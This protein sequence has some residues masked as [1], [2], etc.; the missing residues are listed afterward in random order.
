MMQ[1]NDKGRNILTSLCCEKGSITGSWVAQSMISAVKHYELC[2]RKERDLRIPQILNDPVFIDRL[3]SG[4][5]FSSLLR[6]SFLTTFNE[7]VAKAAEEAL[8]ALGTEERGRRSCYSTDISTLD[9]DLKIRLLTIEELNH[10]LGR[11]I[12]SDWK[13]ESLSQ[14]L[15]FAWWDRSCDIA[16]IVGTF[17]HGYGNYEAILQD[18][19]MP[20]YGNISTW[21]KRRSRLDQTIDL[22]RVVQGGSVFEKSD[23]SNYEQSKSQRAETSAANLSMATSKSTNS[24]KSKF[25][26]PAL[27]RRVHNCLYKAVKETDTDEISQGTTVSASTKKYLDSRLGLIIHLINTHEPKESS[28]SRPV[29]NNS[30]NVIFQTMCE[31]LGL[32]E[33]KVSTPSHLFH[34]STSSFELVCPT[35]FH[36]TGIP[37][38][39]KSRGLAT[40]VYANKKAL[41]R[42][43]QKGKSKESAH[44][45]SHPQDIT[46]SQETEYQGKTAAKFSN[47]ENIP[48]AVRNDIKLRDSICAAYLCTGSFDAGFESIVED[49]WGQNSPIPLEGD[50]LQRYV[51][52]I[53]IPHCVRLCFHCFSFEDVGY[54]TYSHYQE[55]SFQFPSSDVKFPDPMIELDHHSLQSREN[56]NALLRRASLHN[57][58]T[59]LFK[60]EEDTKTLF[61]PALDLLAKV[62]DGLPLW[63][64]SDFDWIM[65]CQAQKY[66]ILHAI[67]KD[68]SIVR[69]NSHPLHPESLRY[70]VRKVFLQGVQSEGNAIAMNSPIP[71]DILQRCSKE[72]LSDFIETQIND[73]PSALVVEKRLVL[74]CSEACKLLMKKSPGGDNA[75]PWAFYNLPMTDHVQWET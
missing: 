31:K 4:T 20:F 56:A 6:M 51:Y 10:S 14:G 25:D 58:L 71:Q 42:V 2:E 73:F 3:R 62:K 50:D 8:S 27:S 7:V 13:I 63:W 16:L 23:F 19:N 54:N 15:P 35:N 44:P 48:T 45:P 61:Q 11:Q 60:I 36:C 46:P 68:C 18:Q 24:A 33:R 5:A 41:E 29:Q 55:S 72:D 69:E 53:L 17:L 28:L 34:E 1:Q 70:H 37:A 40:L 52:D 26:L 59:Y 30:R 67:L 65:L 12:S 38:V 22:S 57:S 39:L 64:T 74:L 66:G 21:K 43:A 49:L 32:V 47:I 75:Y 9:N